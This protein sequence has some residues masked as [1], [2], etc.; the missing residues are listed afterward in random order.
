MENFY[1]QLNFIKLV[2]KFVLYISLN[3]N[4][5]LEIFLTRLKRLINSNSKSKIEGVALI[6]YIKNATI[7]KSVNIKN[8]SFRYRCILSKR[9]L[10]N[11][12]PP[13]HIQIRVANN[14][15]FLPVLHVSV[16]EK[17]M[18]SST[19]TLLYFFVRLDTSIM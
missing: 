8:K 19:T 5:N 14:P 16:T 4:F 3:F 2:K 10:I 13:T 6:L 15:I 9:C 7:I 18:L 11:V 1:Y 12:F 17:D